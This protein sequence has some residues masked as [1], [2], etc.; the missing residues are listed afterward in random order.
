ME[1]EL[2]NILNQL[3][4]ENQILEQQLD[5]TSRQLQEQKEAYQN[6]AN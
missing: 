5:N 1:Q 2:N 6:L 3:E 4:K